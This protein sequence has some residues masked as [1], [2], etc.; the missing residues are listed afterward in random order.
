MTDFNIKDAV[1]FV[2]ALVQE[3]IPMNKEQFEAREEELRLKWLDD[4]DAKYLYG[5]LN[6]LHPQ[7]F[8]FKKIT[9][10]NL[11]NSMK[12]TDM[13]GHK[14][15]VILDYA[16]GIGLSSLYMAMWYPNAQIIYYEYGNRHT[17]EIARKL[18]KHFGATNINIVSNAETL[19]KIN[20]DIL[21]TFETL[22]H[23]KD[24]FY[25][26][27][28]LVHDDLKLFWE[29]SSF[30]YSAAGHFPVFMRDGVEVKPNKM[31]ANIRNYFS[32]LNMFPFYDFGVSRKGVTWNG[33]P[34]VFYKKQD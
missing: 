32:K 7:L 29:A 18:F 23:F 11:R 20:Y 28:L 27:D 31:G 1:K 17:D 6:Y 26:L 25:L 13:L 19:A 2:E 24:P 16:A 15:E 5:E 21:A 3:K 34:R 22:E 9:S 8:C 4:F 14:P 33:H 12:I 30:T 10:G